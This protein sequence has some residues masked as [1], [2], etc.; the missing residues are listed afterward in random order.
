[1]DVVPKKKYEVFPLH[2]VMK[3]KMKQKRHLTIVSK[4]DIL[5]ERTVD[6]SAIHVVSIK[7]GGKRWN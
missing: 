6:N 2:A 5:P 1:L 3:I 4:F 7:K